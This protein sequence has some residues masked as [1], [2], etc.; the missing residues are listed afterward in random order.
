MS[1]SSVVMSWSS[2]GAGGAGAATVSATGWLPVKAA[3]ALRKRP[4]KLLSSVC[5]A[6]G[7]WPGMLGA[8]MVAV[9]LSAAHAAATPAARKILVIDFQFYAVCRSPGCAMRIVRSLPVS[10]WSPVPLRT[11]GDAR[12]R[13][14]VWFRIAGRLMPCR[15]RLGLSGR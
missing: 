12:S 3:T 6:A 5:V 14:L 9:A 4:V 11:R 10:L 15:Q 1:V 2:V 8:A 7:F 13:Y